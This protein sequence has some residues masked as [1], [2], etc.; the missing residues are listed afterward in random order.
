[1]KIASTVI[2]PR[3]ACSNN[4][5]RSDMALIF[6][7]SEK[8]KCLDQLSFF[9]NIKHGRKSINHGVAYKGS[10]LS[11]VIEN[12]H[13]NEAKSLVE[14]L[15]FYNSWQWTSFIGNGFFQARSQTFLWGGVKSVKFW[16][17]LW[18]RVD[19]LAI[20]LDLAILGGVT[21]PPWPPPGYG[22]T[23]PWLILYIFNTKVNTSP[24]LC[25]THIY[26]LKGKKS[27]TSF[28]FCI[29]VDHF[30]PC[31]RNDDISILGI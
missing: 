26:W 24:E 28:C 3:R 29:Q 27:L 14:M 12:Q 13:F 31:G 7:R 4:S 2:N 17:L 18:L 23:T 8:V 19:Y 30:S 10:S 15:I 21:W 22:P 25:S 20:A 16:D 9:M 11:R 6:L 5:L 1:M